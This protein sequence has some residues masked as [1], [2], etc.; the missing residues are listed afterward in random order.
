MYTNKQLKGL[1]VPLMF[2]QLLNVMVG[3]VDTL[4][5]SRAGE[6]AVSGVALTTNINLLIIQVM[7][8]LSTGGAVVCSQ[9]NGRKDIKDAKFAA[10]QLETVMLVFSFFAASVC[11]FGGKGL[12]GAIFGRV[13]D[14]V[15]EG[16]LTYMVITAVSYPFLGLYN[17]G[18]AIFRSSGNSKISMKLSVLMNV[19]N[20]GFNAL[21]VFTLVWG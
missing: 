8:A 7:A 2:E 16:A 13:E 15:M 1:V 11:I 19:I 14:S 18:A 10:G 9:Y 6:A 21:F 3:I 4:M 17:A 12:L 20:I 5:V